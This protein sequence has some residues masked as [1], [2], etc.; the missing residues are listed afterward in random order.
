MVVI[1]KSIQCLIISIF[2]S[3]RYF[4]QVNDVDTKKTYLPLVIPVIQIKL[5]KFGI[6]EKYRQL[7]QTKIRKGM[8]LKNF[9][10]NGEDFI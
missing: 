7:K 9:K 1:Q 5:I 2:I 10:S 3:S 6:S 8:I 4:V